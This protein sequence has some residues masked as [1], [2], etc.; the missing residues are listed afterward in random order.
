MLVRMAAEGCRRRMDRIG[1]NSAEPWQRLAHVMYMDHAIQGSCNSHRSHRV[2]WPVVLL[3]QDPCVP[4]NGHHAT[5][6]ARG[7]DQ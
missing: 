6:A 2:L 5:L 4:R 3:L 7:R 1:L